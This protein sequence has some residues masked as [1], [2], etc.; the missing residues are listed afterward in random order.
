MAEILLGLGALAIGIALS[1]L[2]SFSRKLATFFDTLIHE[3]G[4]G[5]A[6]LPFGAPLPTITV[7]KNTSGETL[8]AMGYLHQLLPLGLG[9]LTEKI[10]RTLSLM[11]GYSAS[12][13]FA[14]IL[15]LVALHSEISF[16]PWQLL[17]L[18][19]VALATVLWTLVR[20]TD[21]PWTFVLVAGV[22]TLLYWQLL[23]WNW[24]VF[25]GGIVAIVL[26]FILARSWLASF[27]VILTL[28]AP[29]TPLLGLLDGTDPLSDF[30]SPLALTVDGAMLSKV[31]FGALLVFLLFCCRSPLSLGLT[32]LIIGPIFGLLFIPGL[33]YSYVL[34]AVT[35]LL[36]PAGV[37]SLIELHRLTF[38]ATAGHWQKEQNATDM[39]FASEEIGGDPRYWY[40]LQAAIAAIIPVAI[41]IVGMLL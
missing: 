1:L 26:L 33:S 17:F 38:T 5:L 41:L 9:S 29:L 12:T 7:R 13:I 36:I 30:L 4:H 34:L 21:S 35:G 15:V 37:R 27:A 22:A 18:A 20:I 19:Q 31:I 3:T 24:W 6:S 11:A 40:W 32:A 23:P 39:V 25:G 16:E 14:S 8:S 28:T 10:A 2:P